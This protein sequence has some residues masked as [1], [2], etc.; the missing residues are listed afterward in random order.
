MR[1]YREVA[2]SG[3]E[4]V[5]QA[6]AAERADPAF[7]DGVRSGCP[8]RGAEDADVGT[9]EHRVEGCGELAAAVADQEPKLVG[10]VAELHQQV[11]GL[12]GD[13]G[14]G[15]MGGDPGEVHA[16]AAVLDHH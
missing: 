12:L 14:L 3:D 4:E 9:G 8:C 1:H 16:A 11:A 15:G 6:F 13:P 5:V 2:R 7:R 10:P